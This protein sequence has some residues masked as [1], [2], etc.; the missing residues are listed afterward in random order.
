MRRDV[1][2]KSGIYSMEMVEYNGKGYYPIINKQKIVGND[3]EV[4]IV[5]VV[6][7]KQR[8]RVIDH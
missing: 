3:S 8:L 6:N 1:V 2:K 4:V 5:V 7:T